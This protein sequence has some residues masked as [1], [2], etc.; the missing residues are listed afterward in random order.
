[1]HLFRTSI[2][3]FAAALLT[4]SGLNTVKAQ[5]PEVAAYPNRP[6]KI[7]VPVAPGGTVDIVARALAEALTKPLGQQVIVENKPGASSLLGTNFVAKSAPDGYTLLAHSTTFVTAPVLLKNAGYD[8][9]KDFI[10]ITVTCQI[11]MVLVVNPEKITARTLKDFIAL[12]KAQ[13][14]FYA[15][16]SSGNG[17]TGHIA[18]ELFSRAADVS[19]LHVPYKGNAQSMVD[20][21]GGQVPLMFDQVS[22][23]AQY[24]L[25]GKIAAIGVTSKTRSPILPN[26]PTLDE[27]GLTGFEDSTFNGLFAPA[28]TPAAIIKRLHTEL[29]KILQSPDLVKQ[30]MAKGV[31]LGASSTPEQFSQYLAQQTTRYQ[32]LARSANISAD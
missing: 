19:Y 32:E 15:Y 25:S 26:V 1:M 23:S 3:S 22:T 7:I 20:L 8:P 6:I 4:L 24:V 10:P 14:K 30:F 21:L 16:A 2:I 28:G 11:P 12:S 9:L 29:T 18:A 13:P 17:S 27:S 31:E 5:T